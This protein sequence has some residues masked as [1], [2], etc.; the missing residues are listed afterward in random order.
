MDFWNR[1]AAKLPTG[2]AAPAI[3]LLR[4]HIA[5]RSGDLRA[6]AD[7]ELYRIYN[8]QAAEKP[9]L[10]ILFRPLADY[11]LEQA[12]LWKKVWPEPLGIRASLQ[13]EEGDLW[14][15]LTTLEDFVAMQRDWMQRAEPSDSERLQFCR[16]LSVGAAVHSKLGQFQQSL[17]WFMQAQQELDLIPLT[18]RSKEGDLQDGILQGIVSCQLMDFQYAAAHK[19]ITQA[20][21]GGLF[22]AYES[23]TRRRL[24]SL[25]EVLAELV[26]QTRDY[27]FPASGAGLRAGL[28]S[29]IQRCA[30]SEAARR[31]RHDVL[32]EIRTHDVN[33]QIQQISD[34]ILKI[35]QRQ[36][37]HLEREEAATKAEEKNLPEFPDLELSAI[38]DRETRQTI[39]TVTRAVRDSYEEGRRAVETINDLSR[40][41]NKTL[42]NINEA[43]SKRIR[44]AADST[45]HIP[46]RFY[47]QWLWWRFRRFFIQI[48]AVSYL[49]EK[50]VQEVVEKGGASLLERLHFGPHEVILD[51]TVLFIAFFA[52]GFVE[53]RVDDWTLGSYKNTLLRVVADRFTMLWGTYNF[54]LKVHAV[55]KHAQAGLEER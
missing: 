12:L 35:M 11:Y 14:N 31:L 17:E 9:F 37:Q 39:H 47:A 54:L 1:V 52:G 3:A 50:I 45:Y 51:V 22:S 34:A 53:K 40:S 21:E 28:T 4:S 23:A 2:K 43:S 55:T 6:F 10:A 36:R 8:T 41:I 19:F 44:E 42:L 24:R 15:G 20:L 33:L 5:E 26:T 49:L 27:Q 32:T 48:I 25:D 30:T 7:L 16:Y 18:V 29:D 13:I 38:R 46:L